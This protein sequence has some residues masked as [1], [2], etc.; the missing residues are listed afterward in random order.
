MSSNYTAHIVWKHFVK[1]I[2]QEIC[3]LK[4]YSW[5]EDKT[6]K[7]SILQYFNF[8]CKTFCRT[9]LVLVT[10]RVISLGH[11]IH[12]HFTWPWHP[13]GTLPTHKK[14]FNRVLWK[15][16][17]LHSWWPPYNLETSKFDNCTSKPHNTS[18]FVKPHDTYY[19]IYSPTQNRLY[20]KDM[21]TK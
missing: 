21:Q 17:C 7:W 6:L 5:C 8:S 1:D 9:S 3:H 12:V 19:Y 10:V 4:L 20:K 13:T 16:F 14:P 2:S 11:E 18:Y 15:V